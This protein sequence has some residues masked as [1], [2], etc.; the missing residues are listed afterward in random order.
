MATWYE[1]LKEAMQEDGENFEK[2]RREEGLHERFGSNHHP[3]KH[4]NDDA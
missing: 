3:G 1:M 2:R 4:S